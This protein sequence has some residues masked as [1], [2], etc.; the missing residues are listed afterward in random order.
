MAKFEMVTG[1]PD[2][3]RQVGE[4]L[5]SRLR[6][7]EVICL[8][9]PLGAGKTTFVQGLARGL[10]IAKPVVSPSFVLERIYEGR[11][12]LHHVD[13]YRLSAADEMVESL[14][15][16]AGHQD[17]VVIEWPERLGQLSPDWLKIRLE[18]VSGSDLARRIFIEAPTPGWEEIVKHAIA[19]S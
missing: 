13:L 18:F 8:S 17:V 1:S 9:G 2:M 11:A 7:G 5:G 19:E 3:T 12:V 15:S 14:L 10:G 16:E 4:K 6:G